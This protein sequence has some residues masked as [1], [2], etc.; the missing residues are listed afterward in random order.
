MKRFLNFLIILFLLSPTALAEHNNAHFSE[1]NTHKQQCILLESGEHYATAETWELVNEFLFGE[2]LAA[3]FYT[4][5]AETDSG[6]IDALT[7]FLEDETDLDNKE[8]NYLADALTDQ[9]QLFIGESDDAQYLE[10]TL[11]HE[12]M[13]R[14]FFEELTTDERELFFELY[15]DMTARFPEIDFIISFYLSDGTLESAT[16]EFLS[17]LSEA[18]DY[19]QQSFFDEVIRDSTGLSVNE[20][21][22][23][24]FADHPEAYPIYQDMK[25][26][27]QVD[28]AHCQQTFWLDDAVV[29]RF[30]VET[31]GNQIQASFKL[32]DTKKSKHD[33]SY[34]I[35]VPELGITSEVSP[36]KKTGDAIDVTLTIADEEVTPGYYTVRLSAYDGD[37]QLVEYRELWIE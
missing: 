29:E 30:R 14:E 1:I 21:T 34:T 4:P 12:R 11:L 27:A 18:Q 35:T 9:G 22:T 7:S 10:A 2:L 5:Q 8:Q 23:E 16:T 25:E 37:K 15:Q 36:E 19:P 17:Y 3:G 33:L 26:Q 20:F 6:F 24:L 28:V 32:E 13:H 31:V